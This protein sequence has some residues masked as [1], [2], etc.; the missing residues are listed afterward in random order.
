MT[1]HLGL[2]WSCLVTKSCPTLCDCKLPGSSVHGTSQARI[3]EQVAIS[4]FLHGIFQAQGWNPRLL[5]RQVHPLPLSHRGSPSGTTAPVLLLLLNTWWH[6]SLPLPLPV[7]SCI[8]WPRALQN[9]MHV[10]GPWTT[11]LLEVTCVWWLIC[12]LINIGKRFS[13]SLP[14]WFAYRELTLPRKMRQ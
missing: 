3:L 13:W 11:L 6:Y 9:D 2:C 10:L 1:N 12:P 8:R 5:V 7:G 14:I 4:F